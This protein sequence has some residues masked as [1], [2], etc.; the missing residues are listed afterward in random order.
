MYR[1]LLLA[2]FITSIH[3][4]VT[5]APFKR[6]A[7]AGGSITEIIYRLGQ[8]NHIVGVDSTSVFPAETKKHPLLG[9]VRNVSVEG[10]LSL[11]PDLVLGEDDTGPAKALEQIKAIGIKTIIIKEDN[12]IAALKKKVTRIAQLLD[13]EERGKAL[14][15]DMQIDLDALN[16]AKAHLSDQAKKKPPKV[17]FLLT[18]QHGVPIAAGHNTPAHTV[19]EAAG[20][21][22]MMAQHQGWKKLSPESALALNPDV[23]VVM[24]RG[25]NVFEQ[26]N[27]VP[28]FQYTNAVKN[29]AIHTID[30][31][32][33]LGFG[34]RTPQAIV[35]LGT[36]IHEQFTLPD[37]YQFRYPNRIAPIKAH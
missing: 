23:I 12:T 19:I 21:I 35:E 9:Y 30:G 26:V 14:L 34:P 33:L 10:V 8:Q 18:L 6:I 24:N 36:M 17:L 15:E 1:L 5:A 13:S 22:N 37:D 7:V 32:Y 29:K 11:N 27:S 2:C 28:H 20:G 31:V 3:S 4:N 25:G 16:Y